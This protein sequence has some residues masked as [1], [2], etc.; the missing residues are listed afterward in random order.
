MASGPRYSVKFRRRRE[1]K[2]DYRSRL[3]LLKSKITRMVVRKTGKGFIVQFIDFS[4]RG[5]RVVA[6]ALSHELRHLGWEFSTRSTP[7]AYLTGLLATKRA[8]HKVRKAVLDIGSASPKRGATVFAALKGALDGG[9]SITHS[10]KVIPSEDRLKGE[11][12]KAHRDLAVPEAFE[13]VKGAIES[14]KDGKITKKVKPKRPP[15]KRPKPVPPVARPPPK[16]PEVKP[17]PKPP[18]VKPP[19]T[20]PA[21]KP[22][23]RPE[24]KPEP[25]KEEKPKPVEEKKPEKKDKK[26][27]DLDA[28]LAELTDDKKEK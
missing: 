20:P 19:P 16:P 13:Q 2:T 8:G 18:A 23:P 3:A 12:I 14:L 25:V 28:L 27:D 24:P 6:Q 26:M 9:I 5:D 15:V 21:V 17:E 22:E 7:A 11:H 10:E 1:G 4:T